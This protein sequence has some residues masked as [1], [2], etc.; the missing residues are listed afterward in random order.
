MYLVLGKYAL[1][2][3]FLGYEMLDHQLEYCG[4][5][6]GERGRLRGRWCDTHAFDAVMLCVDCRS[7]HWEA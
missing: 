2:G 5:V 3:T 7:V 4:I 1:N 6:A